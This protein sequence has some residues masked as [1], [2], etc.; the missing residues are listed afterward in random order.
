MLVAEGLQLLRGG[1]RV[2]RP[3]R[4]LPVFRQ[5]VRLQRPQ[6][7]DNPRRKPDAARALASALM[8]DDIGIA[9]VQADL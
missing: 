8:T 5:P 7:K 9:F 4:P 3:N 2:A 1:I 6:L